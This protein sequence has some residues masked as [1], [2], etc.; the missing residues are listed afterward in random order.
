MG[1][2]LIFADDKPL[3]AIGFQGLLS[4]HPEF[5][6]AAC[7]ANDEEALQAARHHRPD[8]LVLDL[9]LPKNGTLNLIR[10][11]R[12][13]GLAAKVVI[14]ATSLDED[15]LLDLIRLGVRGV[16][17]K[18]M[19]PDLI[20]KCLQKVHAGGE[21]LENRSV[22]L[23]LE[24]LLHSETKRP[25]VEDLLTPR[26]MEL[27]LLAAAGVQNQE[28]ALRL[29]IAEGTVKAHLHT[30]YGKLQ[31]KNRLGL[32]TLVRENGWI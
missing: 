8:L 14:L 13:E 2:R 5:E 11:I 6:V 1:I 16:V 4:R 20:I 32:S 23:A 26:E 15:E 22:S 17:L 7:C 31:V 24:K 12:S 25:R 28:I 10:D 30:I 29:G 21:W 19:A 27:L 3:Y 9:H 18:T